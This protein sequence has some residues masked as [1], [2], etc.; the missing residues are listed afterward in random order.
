MQYKVAVSLSLLLST[1]TCVKDIAMTNQLL[2]I[3]AKCRG[4][5]PCQFVGKDLFL[6]ISIRNNEKTEIGFPLAF[7]Q[8]TGPIIRLIDTRTKAE[9]HLHT[10][11]AD[12]AL[13]ERFTPVPPGQSVA[14]E[15]VIMA[16][17]L[18]QFGEIVDLSAEIT[19]KAKIKVGNRRA[20]FVGADTLRIVGR[21]KP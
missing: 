16:G 8:K 14:L 11:P 20:D 12:F 3:T 19:L 21:D 15:W 17:E 2:T 10:N 4:S 7:V 5:D 13:L 6:D 9:T 1:C 18:K